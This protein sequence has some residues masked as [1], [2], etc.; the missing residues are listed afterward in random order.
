MILLHIL[1]VIHWV[2][3]FAMLEVVCGHFARED[4]PYKAWDG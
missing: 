4:Q 2:A 3:L 1:E